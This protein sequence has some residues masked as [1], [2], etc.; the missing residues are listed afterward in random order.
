MDVGDEFHFYQFL[1][2]FLSLTVQIFHNLSL[3]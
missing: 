1:H 2:L 3:Q